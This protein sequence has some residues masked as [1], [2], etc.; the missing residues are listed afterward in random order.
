MGTP[1]T[2]PAPRSPHLSRLSSRP[3]PP[4]TPPNPRRHPRPPTRSTSTSS[5]ICYLGGRTGWKLGNLILNSSLNIRCVDV[6]TRGSRAA[7]IDADLRA[8]LSEVWNPTV[9]ELL[10]RQLK[11]LED[12]IIRNSGDDALDSRQARPKRLCPCAARRKRCWVANI[13]FYRPKSAMCCDLSGK[14]RP[15]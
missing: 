7:P 11:R 12:R 9:A 3:F 8:V 6:V 1:P 15:L 10:P 14:R 13:I 5:L 4:Q 2:V